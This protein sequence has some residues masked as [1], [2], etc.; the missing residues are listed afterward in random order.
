MR[1]LRETGAAKDYQCFWEN[2]MECAIP[3]AEW[4]LQSRRKKLSE[5]VNTALE[6]FAIVIYYNGS[7]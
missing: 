1:G 3:S 5:Y 2:F 4:K 7:P 6:A